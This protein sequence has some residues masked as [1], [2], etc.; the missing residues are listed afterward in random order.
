MTENLDIDFDRLNSILLPDASDAFDA[1][2]ENSRFVHYTS[3]QSAFEI[4]KSNCI[5][6]RNATC[7]ND[8]NEMRHGLDCIIHAFG[9]DEGKDFG[10]N[11]DKCHPGIY[12]E[13]DKKFTDIAP[14][15]ISHTYISCFSEHNEEEEL[16]GRLS[17]WRAY[18]S[19]TGV[20]IVFN[21]GAFVRPSNALNVWTTPVTYLDKDGVQQRVALIAQNIS[22]NQDFI[23]SIDRSLVLDAAFRTLVFMVVGT[24]HKGFKEEREWRVVHFPTI[25]PANPDRI[26]MDQV[27]IGG[28]PQPIFQIPFQDYPDEG[29][30]GATAN[31]LIHKIIIGPTQY[32]VALQIA[33]AQVLTKSGVENSMGRIQ[34]SDVTL[35][36]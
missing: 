28:V 15:L 3:A 12:E 9:S 31:E 6:M 4:L 10:I 1:I 36:V 13:L 14:V 8:Y 16:S 30:Y 22:K 20:A 32:P 33:L 21:N 11:L 24:K 19:T 7:M 17:M 2:D 5:W 35:R 29:F 23:A 34:L 18:G 25:W 27:V 26:P